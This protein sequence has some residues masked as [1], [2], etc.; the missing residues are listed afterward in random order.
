MIRVLHC[1]ETISSGGVEQ[2]LLTLIQ[3]LDKGRF[4]HRII[5]TWK[6]GPVAEALEREGVEITAVGAFRHPFEWQ[7]HKQVIKQIKSFKPHILHGAIFEGISMAAIG[8]FFGDVPVTVFEETSDPQNRSKKANLL[9]RI[10]S[11]QADVIQAISK[12]VGSFLKEKTGIKEGKIRIIPNGVQ[13]PNHPNENELDSFKN[14]YSI[15]DGHFVV[16]F[17]GRLHDD[18]KRV[19]D[20]IRAIAILGNRN[21][22]VLIIGDGKD[23]NALVNLADS[24]GVLDQI[25]FT[26]FQSDTNLFYCLMDILVIPSSREGFGLVAAEAML[27]C[28]PVI[29]SKV[30]GLQDIIVDVETGFLVPPLSPPAIAEKIQLLIDQPE[31]RK[32]MGNK[33]KQHA[34]K[35]FTAERY[36]KEVEQL[37]LELLEKKGV[38]NS[39][40]SEQRVF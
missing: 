12:N 37:Y 21:L 38:L 9:L 1:I 31:L 7:K 20:L 19:S 2:T 17:T 30:G 39:E 3:G 27:Q 23:K 40:F 32:E 4:E 5:C 18:H 13:I 8:T 34:L 26:G 10:F 11:T 33:G 28:L 15:D 16:G 22:K 36:C 24:L 29:A 6:G 25:I 14:K 35:H